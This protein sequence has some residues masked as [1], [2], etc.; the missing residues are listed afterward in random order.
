MFVSCATVSGFLWLRGRRGV[1]ALDCV[2]NRKHT[3]H[4]LDDFKPELIQR[5]VSRLNA[6]D[7][8]LEEHNENPLCEDVAN[9]EDEEIG[10]LPNLIEKHLAHLLLK[11]SSVEMKREVAIRCLKVYLKEKEEDLFREQLDGEQQF[12]EE[13]VKIVVTRRAA[14]SLKAVAKI[15]IE[16]TAVLEDLDVPRVCALMMGLIYT[17]NLSYP[18]QVKNT[19]EVFLELDGL[20]PVHG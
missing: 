2:R 19:L 6:G 17:L 12:P 7:D 15:V 13:V 11:L 10:E 1:F 3:P 9:E 4:S 5:C 8:P 20:K 14:V 16:G 18:K